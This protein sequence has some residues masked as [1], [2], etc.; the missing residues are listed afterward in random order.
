MRKIKKW[1]HMLLL[2]IIALV[3]TTEKSKK[4]TIEWSHITLLSIVAFLIGWWIFGL[5]GA[6]VIALIVMFLMGIIKY[7]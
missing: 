4:L 7:Q 1:N 5:L 6:I 3:A 2:S